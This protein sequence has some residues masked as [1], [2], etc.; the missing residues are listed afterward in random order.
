[1]T[2]ASS[3]PV[4]TR[5]T[6]GM[7]AARA[8]MAHDAGMRVR[9]A[10][11]GDVRHARQHDVVDELAAALQQPARDWAAAPTA[12]VGVRAGRGPT[13]AGRSACRSWRPPPLPPRPSRSHRRSRGSRCSG[14][15]CRTGARGSR[16][17]TARAGRSSSSAAVS[18]MPGVQIAALQRVALEE[19][20]LQ[21]AISPRSERPSMVSTRRA[22]G[23]RREHQAAAHDLAVDPHRAG[24]AHAVLAADVACRSAADP[25]AGN[26]PECWRASTRRHGLAVH[27]ERDVDHALIRALSRPAGRSA[28]AAA[29][30]PDAASARRARLQVAGRLEV[31]CR[32]PPAAAIVRRRPPALERLPAAALAP[33]SRRRRRTPGAPR[34]RAAVDAGAAPRGRPSRSRRGG[35]PTPRTE[36][37]PPAARRD[38]HG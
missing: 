34:Q 3:A 1:M 25:R 8:S 20:L 36:R 21:V 23:L 12:D 19:G 17:A 27:G 22:V 15:S 2:S 31:G 29:R 10:H 30:R 32:A 24:A 16:R 35:G 4:T 9:A 11:E 13:G 33:A 5:I 37:D 18:S 7:R 14:S 6:P 26:R 38:R 28:A